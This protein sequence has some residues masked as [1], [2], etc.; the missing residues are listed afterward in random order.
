METKSFSLARN[1]PYA[2]TGIV[3]LA[4]VPMAGELEGAAQGGFDGGQA[5]F[6]IALGGMAVADRE[7]VAGRA[8]AKLWRGLVEH[9]LM[10]GFTQPVSERW[11]SDTRPIDGVPFPLPG[12]SWSTLSSAEHDCQRDICF[13]EG[14]LD[15]KKDMISH[16]SEK[17]KSSWL[18]R[19]AAGPLTVLLSTAERRQ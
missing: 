11:P 2:K 13:S 1:A 16:F 8:A 18:C 5:D 15:S 3:L 9:G 19:F 14:N 6:A 7:Q 12:P 17:A 10:T 4:A